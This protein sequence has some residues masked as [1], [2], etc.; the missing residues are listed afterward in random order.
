MLPNWP[1]SAYLAVE[2]PARKGVKPSPITQ[3]IRESTNPLCASASLRLCVKVLPESVPM[4]S[5]V[6]I[7]N[8]SEIAA[9]IIRT[10]QRLGISTVAVYSEADAGAVH[11]Q[12]ADQSVCIGPRAGR[13]FLPQ[14]R[15]RD[16]RLPRHR[17]RRPFTPATGS[18][19]RTAGWS[20]GA[21][22]LGVVF[23]GPTEEVLNQ[24]GDQAIGSPGRP[25]VRPPSDAGHGGA[26]LG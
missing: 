2:P 20:I 14:H 6:L 12:L 4:F 17:A 13:R 3:L 7:A 23:I 26:G 19:P 8:R 5:K 25:Q 22:P 18:S 9:R 16:G 1:E 11:T 10:C 15:R 24:M 21:S